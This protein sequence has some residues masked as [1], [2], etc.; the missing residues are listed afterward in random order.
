[1]S[2]SWK[3]PLALPAVPI[4]VVQLA[5]ACGGP[6]GTTASPSYRS[7]GTVTMRLNDDWSIPTGAPWDLG[8]FPSTN[9]QFISQF[10]WTDS[11]RWVQ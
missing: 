1:M 11:S 10:I 3:G 5:L 4:L 2:S 9:A 7:G 6:S 8:S